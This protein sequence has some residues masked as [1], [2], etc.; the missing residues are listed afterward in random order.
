MSSTYFISSF[1]THDG[2]YVYQPRF[3]IETLVLHIFFII[4]VSTSRKGYKNNN[5]T[6]NFPINKKENKATKSS[7]VQFT[8]NDSD[9]PH[10]VYSSLDLACCPTARRFA[11]QRQIHLLASQSTSIFLHGDKRILVSFESDIAMAIS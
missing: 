10:C 3:F 1:Y 11:F 2:T 7:V 6:R 4:F 8:T 5:C 9:I